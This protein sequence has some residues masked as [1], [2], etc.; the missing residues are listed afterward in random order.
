MSKPLIQ[1]ITSVNLFVHDYD[2]ALDFYINKL[3]FSLV[4]DQQI[5]QIQR[6]IQV[7]P[8]PVSPVKINVSLATTEIQKQCVGQQAGDAVFMIFNTDNFWRDYK[9]LQNKGVVFIEQPREED[10]GTVAIFEDLYG[11]KFDLIETR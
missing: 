5:D 8:T 9:S 2:E 11:N 10:Y 3:G 7:A 4:V 6:W 1:N